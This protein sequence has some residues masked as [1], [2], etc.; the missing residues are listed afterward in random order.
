MTGAPTREGVFPPVAIPTVD[1]I[2]TVIVRNGLAGGGRRIRTPAPRSGDASSQIGEAHRFDSPVF[3]RVRLIDGVK[4][5]KSTRITAW[6]ALEE[7]LG[8]P[9]RWSAL[10]TALFVPDIAA[11]DRRSNTM[12]AYREVAVSGSA[13]AARRLYFSRK[14][15][16]KLTA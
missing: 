8:R 10:A 6:S 11:G 1:E 14:I 15:A 13:P 4:S 9:L 12:A 5:C 2:A 7:G 16:L 3:G